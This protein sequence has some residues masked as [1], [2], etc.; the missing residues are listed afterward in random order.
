MGSKSLTVNESLFRVH[1]QGKTWINVCWSYT[2]TQHAK[3]GDSD[4]AYDA[5]THLCVLKL[6]NRDLDTDDWSFNESL[7]TSNSWASIL[8]PLPR[9]TL[10]NFQHHWKQT[11]QE[12]GTEIVPENKGSILPAAVVVVVVGDASLS[13]WNYC[14]AQRMTSAFKQWGWGFTVLNVL[15]LHRRWDNVKGAE[16]RNRWGSEILGSYRAASCPSHNLVTSEEYLDTGKSACSLAWGFDE[17]T[18]TT[19]MCVPL[20]WS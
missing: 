11:K 17:K 16:S 3:R 4:K 1:I 14:V 18:G 2:A 6:I 5:M 12:F 8:F 9:Q 20:I 10:T 13:L 7:L 19:V 15:Q